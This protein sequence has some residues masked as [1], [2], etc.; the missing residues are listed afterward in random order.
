MNILEKVNNASS[1]TWKVL[2]GLVIVAIVTVA[3]GL[4]IASASDDTLGIP[5]DTVLYPDEGSVTLLGSM[6]VP[7]VQ[8][9]LDCTVVVRAGNP[10]SVHPGND[11]LIRSENAVTIPNVEGASGETVF[12]SLEKLTLAETVSVS[13]VAGPDETWSAGFVV[14]FECDTP[15]TTTTVPHIDTTTTTEPPSTTT[16]TVQT[17]TV[18]EIPATTTTVPELPEC[19]ELGQEDP[20]GPQV[21]I[22]GEVPEIRQSIPR[23]GTPNFT[24]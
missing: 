6:A 13:L 7:T 20:R 21:V 19:L 2:Y 24:G 4:A 8:Q 11:L 12:R 22:D 16:L 10:D 15:A 17:T 23:C 18:P 14:T 5:L 9:G 1:N 3:M